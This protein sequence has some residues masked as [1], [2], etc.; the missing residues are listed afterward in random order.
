MF[1][2]KEKGNLE[3]IFYI[4]AMVIGLIANAY[5]NYTKRKEKETQTSEEPQP[6]FPDI[7]FPDEVETMERE[8]PETFEREIEIELEKKKTYGE[9]VVPEGDREPVV[10][11]VLVTEKKLF[12][13]TEEEFQFNL[14]T[15]EPENLFEDSTNDI[16]N[17]DLTGERE[18]EKDEEQRF[19][20]ETAV[21]YS[22]ILKPK[23]INND[24]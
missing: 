7:F 13:T 14:P 21:I 22:E 6:V 16:Y 18:S 1:Y 19:D 20:L 8:Y 3:I 2:A 4:A 11:P 17:F 5:R 10:S 12:K 9:L 24:Y 23:Y 15:Y